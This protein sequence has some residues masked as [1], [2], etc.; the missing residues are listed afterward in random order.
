M[1]NDFLSGSVASGHLDQSF[2][3]SFTGTV[4]G[5]SQDALAELDAFGFFHTDILNDFLKEVE[6]VIKSNLGPE[7]E[8]GNVAQVVVDNLI[9]EYDNFIGP[10]LAGDDGA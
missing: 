7:V 8:A 4:V 10:V 2:L 3:D 9:I 6:G 1:F 5:I